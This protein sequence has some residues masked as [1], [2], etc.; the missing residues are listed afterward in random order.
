MQRLALDLA[1][2]TRLSATCLGVIGCVDGGYLAV[3]VLVAGMFLV[4][5]DDVCVLQAHLF[6]WSETLELLFGH[7]HKVVALNPQLTAEGD[8]VLAICLVLRIVYGLHLLG[9]TLRI[10]GQDKFHGVEYGAD[11]RSFLVQVV[12]NV[13]FQQGEVVQSVELGIADGIDEVAHTL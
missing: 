4:T 5:L 10:V 3:S 9:L 6:A 7:F 1:V 2:C 11:T 8:G 12:A 13:R